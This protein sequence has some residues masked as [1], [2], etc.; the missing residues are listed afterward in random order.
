MPQARGRKAQLLLDYETT[1]G[2]DPATP[3]GKQMPFNTCSLRGARNL[4]EDG[5]IRNTR[6]PAQP[7]RGN[8]NVEGDVVVP[9]D[10]IGIGYWLRAMFGA[11]TT[12]GVGPY[13]HTFKP[14]DS[15]PSLVLAKEFM[16]VGQYLKYNGCKIS[17]MA[18]TFGGDGELTMTL[19]IMGAKETVGV[20]SYDATPDAITLTRFNQFQATI[21][22]GGVACAIGTE[23]RLEVDFDLDG[24]Q[25]V[26]GG[27]GIR[28]DIPEGMVK[29][30]GSITA[31]FQDATLLNKA[32]NGTESSL[33]VTLTSGTNSLEILIPELIYEQQSPGVEGPRGI[34]IQL[35]FRGYYEDSAEAAVIQVKLTNGQATY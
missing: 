14:G 21:Q 32:V 18:V 5:V 28:G 22:E 24:D 3:V 7:S 31:L 23:V 8:Q 11:P 25:Y 29:P 15:Q 4:V 27:G 20:S 16:D 34:R 30:S 33:K 17:K 2:Q 13:T 10:V 35:P 26:I 19:T 12:T 9:V 1:F 6:N